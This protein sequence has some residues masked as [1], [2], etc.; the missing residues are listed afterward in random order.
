[1]KKCLIVVDFQNDFIDGTL[2]FKG[3]L[4]IKDSI[5]QKIKDYKFNKDDVIYT[6]DTH[7][8]NYMET[9]EG[10]NLPVPHCIKGTKGHE[11]QE[12]VKAVK[13]ETDQSFIKFTF[14]SLE[15]GK[16]LQK[17]NYS[18]VEVCG[19]VSHICVVSNAVIAKSALPNAHIVVDNN[20]T[21]SYDNELHEKAMDILQGLHIEVKNR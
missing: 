10:K 12:D 20:A 16:Y 19:L 4:D 6:L 18:V 8:T 9:E 2:G 7:L 17:Q 15:L 11:L 13:E 5:I 1:M 21:K 3:A 14:P